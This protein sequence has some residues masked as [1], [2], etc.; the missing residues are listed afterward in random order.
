MLGHP[1]GT[2][3]RLDDKQPRLAPGKPQVYRCVDHSFHQEKHVRWPCSTNGG[4]H[5]QHFLVVDVHFQTHRLQYRPSL[6]ALRITDRWRS[7]PHGHALLNLGW[8]IRHD[9][10]H[11]T[12]IE[13]AADRGNGHPGDDRKHQSGRLDVPTQLGQHAGQYLGLDCQN[14]DVGLADGHD[15]VGGDTHAV[16]F[17]QFLPPLHQRVAGDN[18]VR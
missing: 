15:I 8:C 1:G 18:L 3:H 13:P 2:N 11:S 6:G 12:V 10:H 16:E 9:P 17:V 4:R 5:V 14:H 7:G